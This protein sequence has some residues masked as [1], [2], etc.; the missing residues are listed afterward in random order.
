MEPTIGRLVHFGVQTGFGYKVT[1]EH[2][3][4][5]IVDVLPTGVDL[6]VFDRH[7]G[8]EFHQKVIYSPE[9]AIN[10]WSWPVHQE[11]DSLSADPT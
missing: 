5:L 11:E 4:A 8:I 1:P 3:A 10:C 6:I 2:A 7:G 9:L